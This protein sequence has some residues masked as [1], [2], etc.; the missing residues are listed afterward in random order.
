MEIAFRP[1]GIHLPAL[2]LWLD[3]RM[4]VESAWLS[5]GH[6]DHARGLHGTAIATRITM[7][8]YRHRWPLPEGKQQEMLVLDPGQT[9]EWLGARLTA[10]RASHILGAAQLLIEYEGER[11][12][13]TGDIKRRLPICGWPTEMPPCDRLIIESTFGLPI[14]QFVEEHVARERIANFARETI[15]DGKTPVFLGYGLGR[16]Q[17]IV[18]SLTQAGIPCGVHGAIAGLIPYYEAEGYSF[19]GWERYERQKVEDRAL[20]VTPGMQNTLAVPPA[21]MRL[22][23]VSG[24][25]ALDNARARSGADVLIPYSDHGSFGEL[26]QMVEESGARRIDTVHGYVQPL[27][28]ILRQRGHDAEAAATT[29]LMEAEV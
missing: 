3:P 24:W 15:A 22:A 18:Y 16:G 6:S 17:E 29:F 5:H 19:P 7:A 10:C 25:A 12:V 4:P 9:L 8:I 1:E 2:N 14:Y 13:Y 26:L 20:V 27:A 28:R 11:V 23:L 21:R